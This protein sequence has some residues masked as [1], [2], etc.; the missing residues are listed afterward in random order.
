M[1]YNSPKIDKKTLIRLSHGDE[2]AFESIFWA[3]NSYLYN[4]IYSILYDKSMVED[5]TQT[6]FLKIWEKRETID[7]EQNFDAYLF[8]IARHLVYKETE[9]RLFCEQMVESIAAQTDC[10]ASTESLIEALFVKEYIDTLIEQLPPS[11]R[12]IF[13]LSRDS[14]LSNKEIASKL[15]LSEKTV[16]TQIYRSLCYLKQQLSTREGIGLLFLLLSIKC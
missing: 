1:K 14:H 7:P 16:E 12:E 8:T 10:D 2:S 11:R 9:H 13:K 4:F 6:V 5:L 15:S 3:Y